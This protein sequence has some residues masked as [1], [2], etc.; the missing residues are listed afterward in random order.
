MGFQAEVEKDVRMWA[1]GNR[2]NSEYGQYG[3]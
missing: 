2:Y 3:D 1:M